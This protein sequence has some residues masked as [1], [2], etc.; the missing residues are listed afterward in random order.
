MSE[1]TEI[2]LFSKVGAE[3]REARELQK[4]TLNQL[5]NTLKLGEE[6]LQALENGEETLL[7]ERIFVKAMIRRVSQKL[8]LDSEPFIKA[9][10]SAENQKIIFSSKEEKTNN[11]NKL[12]KNSIWIVLIIFI[13]PTLI[14]AFK[15]KQ[16]G[17]RKELI[18]I[19]SVEIN[20]TFN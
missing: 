4:I 2:D 1:K 11:P 15:Q 13:L 20:K 6:Q 10:E 18:S 17:Q 16:E 3:L 14:F 7:P 5:A 8:S 19:K 12:Y 9:I